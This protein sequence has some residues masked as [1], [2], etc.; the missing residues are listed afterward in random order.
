MSSNSLSDMAFC[1]VRSAACT[2]VSALC[3]F[4]PALM[5]SDR[6]ASA[7]N[8]DADEDLLRALRGPPPANYD[9]EVIRSVRIVPDEARRA[10]WAREARNHDTHLAEPEVGE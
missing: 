6:V 8:R 4:T 7:E 2:P 9:D 3:R 10:S 5:R 1:N